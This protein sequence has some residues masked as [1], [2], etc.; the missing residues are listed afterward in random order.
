LISTFLRS[1]LEPL[2]YFIYALAF[3]LEY[4][5]SKLM[6]EKVLIVYYLLATVIISYACVLVFDYDKDNN[7]LYDIHYFLSALVFGYYFDRILVKKINRQIVTVLFI[8]VAI[9]FILSDFIFRHTF[10]NSISNAFLFLS[11]IIAALFYFHELLATVTEK[12]ILLNFNLWVVSGYLVYF[13]G[14][15]LIILS[16]SYFSD[17]L[18][19]EDR[20]I[21]GN[22]WV[23][24][25]VLLFIT[26][27]LTLCSFLWIASQI[28]SR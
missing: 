28:K 16:Y 5:R 6:R 23:V 13:L 21:L 8:L 17:K 27:V 15:F 11:V 10:F 19:F 20:I 4:K 9:N 22:L 14:G 18:S 25:N 26:S 3:L 24:P 7:W 12:N 1:Y 2:S